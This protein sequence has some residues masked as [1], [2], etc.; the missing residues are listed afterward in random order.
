MTGRRSSN[1]S[2]RTDEPGCT[3]WNGRAERMIPPGRPTWPAG[4]GASPSFRPAE[5]PASDNGDCQCYRPDHIAIWCFRFCCIFAYRSRGRKKSPLPIDAGSFCNSRV[6]GT[7]D[8][9]AA[10]ASHC[11][12]ILRLRFALMETVPNSAS[13]KKLP[14]RIIEASSPSACPSLFSRMTSASHRGLCGCGTL[15]GRI[16]YGSRA[17]L[18]CWCLCRYPRISARFS[19]LNRNRL[20][21]MVHQIPC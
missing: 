8:V 7:F 18:A 5:V 19:L 12:P 13:R 2:T 14:N 9:R 16:V 10:N 3:G 17:S 11:E 1:T 4:D 15:N 6:N 20:P 21:V